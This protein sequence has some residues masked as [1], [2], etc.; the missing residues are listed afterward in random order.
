MNCRCSFDL[1]QS[2]MLSH[3][4]ID[5]HEV[6]MTRDHKLR[7]A[8]YLQPIRVEIDLEKV[9]PIMERHKIF[10]QVSI[11][12]LYKIKLKFPFSHV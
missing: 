8:E 11:H 1:K 4:F 3:L 10:L 12:Y 2:V 5:V 6:V 9:L 7:L